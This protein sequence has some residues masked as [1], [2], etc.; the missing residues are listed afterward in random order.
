MTLPYLCYKSEQKRFK[1][2]ATGPG[3]WLDLGGGEGSGEATKDNSRV[4]DLHNGLGG[5]V[6]HWDQKQHFQG[7]NIN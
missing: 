4:S 1:K 5:D 2:K 3:D 7:K 6:F